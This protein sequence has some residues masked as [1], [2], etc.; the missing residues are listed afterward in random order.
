MKKMTRMIHAPLAAITF[1]LLAVHFAP[2]G[3]GVVP[4]PDGG[5]PG[6]Q[7]GRGTKGPF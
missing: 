4:P 7:H 3:F 1:G 6:L 5:Y 2:N